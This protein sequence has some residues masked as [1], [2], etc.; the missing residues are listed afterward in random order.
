MSKRYIVPVILVFIGI[1][2]CCAFVNAWL[3]PRPKICTSELSQHVKQLNLEDILPPNENVELVGHIGGAATSIFIRGSYAYA[4]I[5]PE[6]T[7]FDISNPTH[8][9]KVGFLIQPGRLLTIGASSTS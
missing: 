6:L 4:K 1:I 8:P 3:F 7:I 5:G 9:L 2:S